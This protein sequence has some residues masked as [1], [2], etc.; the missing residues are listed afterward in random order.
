MQLNTSGLNS[1]GLYGASGFGLAGV[2]APARLFP[3][4]LLWS[5][6]GRGR[7]QMNPRAT[8]RKNILS[9]HGQRLGFGAAFGS[10]IPGAAFP[11]SFFRLGQFLHD[12]SLKF[13]VF[14]DCQ[15]SPPFK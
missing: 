5:G 14:E 13:G 15:L 1:G 2:Q 11:F 8:A 12:F 10:A 6:G 3:K 7:I 9:V 4:P